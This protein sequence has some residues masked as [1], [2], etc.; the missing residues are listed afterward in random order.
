MKID[1][2]YSTDFLFLTAWNEWGEGMYL[3]PDEKNK[4]GYLEAIKK[5]MWFHIWIFYRGKY[6]AAEFE[7]KRYP[8]YI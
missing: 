7:N 2:E 4:Y 3:E 8:K 1:K 5:C 6:E